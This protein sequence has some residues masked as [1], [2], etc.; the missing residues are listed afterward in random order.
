MT[1]ALSQRVTTVVAEA[2]YFAGFDVC[3]CITSLLLHVDKHE[4]FQSFSMCDGQGV[5][6]LKLPVVSKFAACFSW[7]ESYL[8]PC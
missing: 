8:W 4:W 2:N 6:D 5:K 7:L 3:V 1:A